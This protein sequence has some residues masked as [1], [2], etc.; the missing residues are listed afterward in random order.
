MTDKSDEDGKT[1]C[2]VSSEI[3]VC[4]PSSDQRHR[5]DPESI[6]SVHSSGDFC[7]TKKAKKRCQKAKECPVS[8]ELSISMPPCAACYSRCP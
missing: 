5:V 3:C 4:D 6:E 7:E 2:V 8:D 1:N